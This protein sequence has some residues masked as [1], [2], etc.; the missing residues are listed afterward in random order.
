MPFLSLFIFNKTGER[1]ISIMR[2]G[3]TL[4]TV[5]FLMMRFVSLPALNVAFLSLALMSMS[6]TSAMLWSI[7]IP[8]LGKTG[9]ASSANGVLDCTGYI[10]AALANL[11]IASV[12][13]H[14]GW[15]TVLLV[16]GSVGLLGFISTFFA[17]KE[18]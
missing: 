15:G 7:Y 16:W 18:K 8:G 4:A 13:S 6:M 14:I 11:L 1:A 10:A 17:K 2:V 12:M 9:R 3:F 5:F